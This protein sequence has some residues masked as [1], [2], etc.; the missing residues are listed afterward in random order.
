MFNSISTV[1]RILILLIGVGFLHTALA[2]F[3]VIPI[4]PKTAGSGCVAWYG[5]EYCEMVSATTGKTWLDRNLGAT[6]ACSA[7]NDTACYGDYYQWGRY[8]DGH[9]KSNATVMSPSILS[10]SLVAGH[11]AF[12]INSTSPYDWV[13]DGVDNNGSL[14]AAN[15]NPCPPGYR[16]PTANELVAENISDSDDA[17]SKLKL[18]SAGYRHINNGSMGSQGSFGYV[19]SMSPNGSNAW[20]LGFSSGYANMYVNYRAFGFSV[21]CLKE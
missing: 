3:Y 18:P 12:I 14:R 21:R 8:T 20:S 13:A 16:I 5:L 11:S 2:D 19:W 10:D 1:K 4:K 7:Y 15:W 9:E 6:Q 17:F